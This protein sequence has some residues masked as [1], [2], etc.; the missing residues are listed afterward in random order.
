MFRSDPQPLSAS[1]V[2]QYQPIT[3]RRVAQYFQ[4]FSEFSNK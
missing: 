4:R 1:R 3:G 2:N